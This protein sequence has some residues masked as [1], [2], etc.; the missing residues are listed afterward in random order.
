MDPIFLIVKYFPSNYWNWNYKPEKTRKKVRAIDTKS[1]KIMKLSANFLT[2][3]LTKAINTK[4]YY[5][6]LHKIFFQKTLK[7]HQW[8]H[9]KR[10]NPIRRKF[11]ILDRW[12]YWT[13][14]LGFVKGLTKT[15]Y[16]VAWKNIFHRFYLR[17]GKIP[18]CKT[19]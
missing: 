14:F 19:S 10:V 6:I 5:T 11:Q 9:F 1:P 7:L 17:I 2:P 8:Y 4:L 3:L 13:R 15:K 12:L 16:Y 18:V